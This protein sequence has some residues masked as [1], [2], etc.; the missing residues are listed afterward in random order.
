MPRPSSLPPLD[1]NAVLGSWRLDVP[2]ALFVLALACWYLSAARRVSRRDDVPAWSRGRTIT[3]LGFGLLPIV[4]VTMSFV[5][6]YENTL[7]WVRALQVLVLL[8]MAP[9]GLAMGKPLTLL[10]DSSS[11]AGRARFDRVL[12]G[13]F[14][15]VLTFP[16]TM[17]ALIIA[18]PLTLYLSGW[19]E[20][21][22]RHPFVDYPTRLLI[23]AIAF[24]YFYSRLQ[25]DPVPREYSH[26]ISII[27]TMAEM[28]GD[29][30]LGVVLWLGPR[31]VAV[32]YYTALHRSWGP[33]IRTDQVIGAGILWIAGDV[34]GTPFLMAL[35]MRLSAVDHEKMKVID[36]ALDAADD[37]RLAAEA[38]ALAFPAGSAEAQP[39]AGSGLWWENDPQFARRFG[40]SKE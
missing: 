34:I 33:S 6:V 5:G 4:L 15:V 38:A 11:P 31:V 3:F 19:Y 10:R 32:S 25:V 2:A 27:I 35:M 30:I 9:M 36:A 12:T 1:L 29:G 21:M 37:Q 13:R 26:L 20:L 16:L 23:V 17:S 24:G 22:L 7:F 40:G 14:F 18:L 39:S 8:M 28:I